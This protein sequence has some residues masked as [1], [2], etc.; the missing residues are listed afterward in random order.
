M[1]NSFADTKVSGEGRGEVLQV[2]EQKSLWACGEEHGEAGCPPC[3]PWRTS[4]ERGS[5]LQSTVE[6]GQRGTE[7]EQQRQSAPEQLARQYRASSPFGKQTSALTQG[8]SM[9]NKLVS[10]TYSMQVPSASPGSLN[11][12]QKATGVPQSHFSWAWG[13]LSIFRANRALPHWDFLS[14]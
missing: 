11:A 4:G 14:R 12:R 2:P 1:R 5:T 10:S 13:C 9:R 8:Q 6:Q 7:K 3:C